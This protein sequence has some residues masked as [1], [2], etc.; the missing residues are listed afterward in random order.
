MFP[1]R[2]LWH[3]LLLVAE[4]SAIQRGHSQAAAAAKAATAKATAVESAHDPSQARSLIVFSEF[5]LAFLTSLLRTQTVLY[6][7]NIN[8]PRGGLTI[9]VGAGAW[10]VLRLVCGPDP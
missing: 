6:D 3:I 4:R 5:C 10:R 7:I 1:R 2:D 8:F 9:V